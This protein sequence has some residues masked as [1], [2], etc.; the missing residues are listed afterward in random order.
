MSGKRTYWAVGPK[1]KSK[2]VCAS[3]KEAVEW[4]KYMTETEGIEG[5]MVIET[6]RYTPAEVEN[7]P[8]F[9]GY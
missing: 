1:G 8:E 6:C 9:D 5:E 3:K 2:I 4:G 7:L